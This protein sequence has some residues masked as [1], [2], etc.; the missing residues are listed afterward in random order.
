VLISLSGIGDW[1]VQSQTSAGNAKFSYC[2]ALT[3]ASCESF[4]RTFIL[5]RLYNV[6]DECRAMCGWRSREKWRRRRID[7]LLK[8]I[9]LSNAG[10]VADITAE[11]GRQTAALNIAGIAQR[12]TDRIEQALR[13]DN[14]PL[15]LTEFRDK[16]RFAA[17]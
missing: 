7:R 4:G 16:G 2:L 10:N 17:P 1:R 6:V 15:P 9:D 13:D 3:D 5:R 11:Y 8:K 12:A 14:L